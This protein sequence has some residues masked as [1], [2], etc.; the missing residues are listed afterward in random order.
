SMTWDLARLPAPGQVPWSRLHAIPA[1]LVTCSNG[2]TTSVPPRSA[3][4][5]A[6]GRPTANRRTDPPYA[7][8]PRAAP[9]AYHGPGGAR[10]LLRDRRAQAA[11]LETARG[12]LLRRGLGV[13]RADVALVTNLSPDHF[14]EY[15]I[16][17]L[18]GLAEVKLTVA[19]AVR[20]ATLVLNADDPV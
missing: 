9:G 20:D 17:D 14:G 4:A 11:V 5:M 12:G 3:M 13:A 19:R 1:A 15:G 6:H 2:N 8:G 7:D 18:D 16:H 10:A